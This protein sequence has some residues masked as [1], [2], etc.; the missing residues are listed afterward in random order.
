[1]RKVYQQSQ[2]TRVTKL[3]SLLP[4]AGEAIPPAGASWNQEGLGMRVE[5]LPIF[6]SVKKKC[7]SSLELSGVRYLPFAIC[8][9]LPLT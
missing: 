1:M 7:C 4:L 3:I 2:A 5:Q 9:S 6:V 8:Y